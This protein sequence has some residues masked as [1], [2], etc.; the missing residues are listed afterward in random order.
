MM[1]PSLGKQISY[2]LNI[3]ITT[4]ILGACGQTSHYAAV[5]ESRQPPSQKVN[6]HIVAKGETLYSIAWR[7]NLDYKQL[8]KANGIPS[9]YRIYPGQR[10]L[11]KGSVRKPWKAP[12]KVVR[13]VKKQP[14]KPRPQPARSKKETPKVAKKITSAKPSKVK[15]WV[16][17]AKG[18]LLAGFQSNSG[19]NKGIDIKGNLEEPV[20]AAAA[21]R[22]VYSGDGLRGYGKL[23][24]VKH[25]EKYLSAYAHNHRLLVKEG[26]YVK[27][28]QKI[29]EMGSTGTDSVKLHFEIRYDGKPVNPLKHLPKK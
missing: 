6:T 24:I 22:I 13:Q 29:A 21:G 19:L 26:A 12:P 23:V 4:F 7:Y 1:T 14:K 18:K 28:G 20:V 10:L 3:L 16:W 9:N 15:K 5:K 2:V 27:Q 25:N 11:L 17:P 8:A